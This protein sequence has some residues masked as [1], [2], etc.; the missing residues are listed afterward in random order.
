MR[1]N[2]LHHGVVMVTPALWPCGA[3]VLHERW[4]KLPEFFR[5]FNTNFF[6]LRQ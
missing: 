5:S 2:T 1:R 6:H 3:V 4:D